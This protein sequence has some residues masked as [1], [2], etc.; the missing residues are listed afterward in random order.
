[1]TLSQTMK[2]VQAM[3]LASRSKVSPPLREITT[4][5]QLSTKA[6]VSPSD[7][8]RWS[9]LNVT[10]L[11]IL[12]TIAFAVSTDTTN[13]QYSSSFNNHYDL[14]PHRIFCDFNHIPR[15]AQFRKYELN[16]LLFLSLIYLI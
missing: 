7:Y 6:G 11:I 3:G 1:M 4:I 5:D 14:F 2:S 16:M 12:L 13:C 15:T 8:P 9:Q 10:V